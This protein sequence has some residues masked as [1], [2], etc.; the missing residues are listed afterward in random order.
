[1]ASFGL[2]G[3]VGFLFTDAFV[4]M[5]LDGTTRDRLIDG[6]TG[7]A[8]FSS[9]ILYV[10][11]MVLFWIA[12]FRARVYPRPAALMGIIGTLPTVAAIMLPP[13]V[14]GLA[15][16][17]ASL[18]IIWVSLALLRSLAGGALVT[19]SSPLGANSRTQ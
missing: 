9:V 6:P 1:M 13:L 15:E 10:L 14:I 17:T 8:I 2:A 16:A 11:G 12:S 7:L 18:A 3:I 4:L 5:Y 19:S